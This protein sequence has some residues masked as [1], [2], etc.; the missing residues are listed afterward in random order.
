MTGYN[1]IKENRIAVP[2]AV[3]MQTI[4]AVRD[5]DRMRE[6]LESISASDYLP[7]RKS[8]GI[9]HAV[10]EGGRSSDSTASIAIK[11]AQLS[12]RIKAIDLSFDRI[13]PRYKEGIREHLIHGYKYPEDFNIKTW[14]KWQKIYIYYAAVSL[15][16]M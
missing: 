14:H 11:T 5:Y 12:R 2:K 16:L 9:P 10:R 8:N 15:G 6:E 7:L 4:W 1:S 13:P 3:Y